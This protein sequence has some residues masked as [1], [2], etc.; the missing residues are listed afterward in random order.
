M[1]SPEEIAVPDVGLLI[2]GAGPTGLGAAYRLREL[3]HDD[4]LVLEASDGV[5]GLARSYT[6]NAGFTYD[7]GGHV[8]FSHFPYYDAVV[9]RLLGEDYATIGRQAWIWIEGQYVAYPFQNHLRG[10]SPQTVYECVSGL[11]A[12]QRA[13]A[14]TGN[15]R[16]WVRAVFGEGIARH[17]MLPYNSKVWAWP[18]EQ[19]SYG[20]IGERVSVVD[21]DAVLRNVILGE[22]TSSW[23][24]NS[25]FRYPLR[26]GT[27]ALWH[28]VAA[29]LSDRIVLDSPVVAV[30]PGTRVA[31]CADGRRYRYERMLSTMPLDE[32]VGCCSGTPAF[33]RAAAL[34]LAASGTH[35]VGVATNEPTTTSKTWIYYPE[36][37]VPFHRVTYLSSYSPY[38]TARPGQTLLLTETSTSAYRQAS[39]EGLEQAVVAAL[40]DLG[41]L[42][43]S[44]AVISTWRCTR[45]KS[46]PVP[47]LER[48]TALAAIHPWLDA[49]SI[50]S[51]GRFGSWRYEIGNMDHSFMQGVEWADKVVHG[52]PERVWGA[53]DVA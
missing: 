3:G 38:L 9:D 23:G 11:M 45:T 46:Y 12:A 50:D 51:R 16:D 47:T 36:P 1:N 30:E 28:G 49:G 22:E 31:V 4:W 29:E 5:G 43:N 25:T 10:L 39:P 20:W 42:R 19:M 24:P 48:D 8:L 15:F 2:I 44:A 6:D 26:G 41:L 21:V 37:Q 33:V 32:L 7:I 14:K 18:L 27:G 40:V 34:R 35:V 17:F 52:A 53:A 13:P